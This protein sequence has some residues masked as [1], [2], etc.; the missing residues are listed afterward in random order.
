MT[1]SEKEILREFDFAF[2]GTPGKYFPLVKENDVVYNFF[3]N[4]EHGYF[5]TARS[6]IHLYG[7][8][9]NWAVV[10]EKT[11]Y[12]NRQQSCY[13]ELTYIGNCINYNEEL[14][15]YKYTSNTN[16]IYLIDP[17]EFKRIEN[18]TGQEMENFE[19]IDPSVSHVKIRD[20]NVK[21]DL[22]YKNYGKVGIEVRDFDNPKNLIGFKDLTRYIN[23]TKPEI[24]NPT[25]EEIQRH[26]S[27]DLP[28]IMVLENFYHEEA[29]DSEYSPSQI[30]TYQLIAKILVNNDASL[31]KPTLTPNNHWSNWDSG[32]L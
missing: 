13:I 3:L 8:N 7:D 25:E 24:L 27:H 30:E 22:N 5:S 18:K 17:F 19:L 4:L 9:D 20:V 16:H 1:F 12:H 31:W 10:F 14:L 29:Y 15:Q 32:S 21:V 2:E 28:K 6:R 11:G 23:E 26:F